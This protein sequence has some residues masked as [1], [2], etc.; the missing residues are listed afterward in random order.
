MLY[1]AKRKCA[2]IEKQTEEKCSLMLKNAECE[3][4][5]YWE[6]VSSELD[7]YIRR[8]TGLKELLS[9]QITDFKQE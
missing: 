4:K 1:A 2:A 9:E 8:H 7:D 5:A 6:K 3:S